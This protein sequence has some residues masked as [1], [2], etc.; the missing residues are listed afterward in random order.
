MKTSFWNLRMDSV[1]VAVILTVVM[2]WG[3][4]MSVS[5]LKRRIFKEQ[6]AFAE[7]Q[8]LESET[9]NG[10][11]ASLTARLESL[12]DLMGTL[13]VATPQVAA[14]GSEGRFSSGDHSDLGEP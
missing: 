10:Q 5:R 11:I 14:E 6:E 8:R 2:V 13:S 1:W 3:T 4:L 9:L 12:E 7:F